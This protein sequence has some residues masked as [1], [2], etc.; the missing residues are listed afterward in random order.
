MSNTEKTNV[1]E[2]IPKVTPKIDQ[3]DYSFLY[4]ENT[5]ETPYE[6]LVRKCKETPTV[7]IGKYIFF[8]Y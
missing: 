2:W 1:A 6:K 4:E 8:F 5:H 3:A 7:P